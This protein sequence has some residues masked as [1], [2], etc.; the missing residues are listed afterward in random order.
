MDAQTPPTTVAVMGFGNPVRRDD[1][2][3]VEVVAALGRRLP[4][5]A[6]VTL[7]DM[8]TSAFEVLFRLKGHDRFILVDALLHA[9][10]PDGTVYRLP[11]SEIEAQIQDDPL[12]FL[13]GLKW[14]QALSYAK[15]LL[16]DQYP[17]GRID[18]YLVAISDTRMQEG[19]SAPVQAACERVVGLLLDELQAV[20]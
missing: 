4:P 16:G 7:F 1:A 14:D 11:A 8:G 17:E 9:P 2:L 6:A 3:G 13:H 5:G 10:D 18:V 20:C 12:V 15:K 19:M